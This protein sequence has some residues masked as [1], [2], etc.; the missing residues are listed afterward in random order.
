MNSIILPVT[1]KTRYYGYLKILK[2]KS[3]MHDGVDKIWTLLY[4]EILAIYE[5]VSA[6]FLRKFCLVGGQF[7]S[8]GEGILN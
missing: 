5:T 6:K 4:Y 7:I 2:D 8:R 1:L 3:L